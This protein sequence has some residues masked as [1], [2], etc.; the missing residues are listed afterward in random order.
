MV[1]LR[2]RRDQ[3]RIPGDVHFK[4]DRTR[5]GEHFPGQTVNATAP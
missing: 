1:G 5:N 3:F 2:E 4:V